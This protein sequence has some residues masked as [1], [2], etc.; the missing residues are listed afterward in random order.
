M[1]NVKGLVIFIWLHFKTWIQ[2][3]KLYALTSLPPFFIVY[4]YYIIKVQNPE[5]LSQ[6]R[7][8]ELFWIS[9]DEYE[10]LN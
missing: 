4:L 2:L 8:Y 9:N 3:L 7:I 1:R 10:L 6:T 5:K